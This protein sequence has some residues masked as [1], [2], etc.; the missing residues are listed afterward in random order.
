MNSEDLTWFDNSP[1]PGDPECKCSL[2][3]E[4]ISEDPIRMW[5]RAGQECRLHERCLMLVV[6]AGIKI[7]E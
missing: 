1:D 5:N 6:K 3:W 2:C 4:V 7:F